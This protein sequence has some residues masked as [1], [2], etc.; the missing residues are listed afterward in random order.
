MNV[1]DF[2]DKELGKVAPYGVYDIAANNG[3]VGVGVTHDTA[4]FA[5]A[6]IRLWL[7]KMGHKRYPNAEEL[8]IAADCGGSNGARVRLWKVKLQELPMKRASQFMSA[9]IRQ[10]HRSGIRSSTAF[11][12][13]SRRIGAPARLQQHGCR[14][15]DRCDVNKNRPAG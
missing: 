13:T 6:S 8:T 3:W 1:H 10:A 15:A 9:T 5:V 14:R 4:E 2:A 12:A 7:E 11:S